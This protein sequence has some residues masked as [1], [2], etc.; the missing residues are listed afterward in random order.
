MRALVLFARQLPHACHRNFEL[1]TFGVGITNIDFIP[2]DP[3]VSILARHF[4]TRRVSLPIDDTNEDS[5]DPQENAIQPPSVMT[6]TQ[7]TTRQQRKNKKTNLVRRNPGNQ[8]NKNRNSMEPVPRNTEENVQPSQPSSS[9]QTQ[10]Q[11]DRTNVS[12]PFLS[13]SIDPSHATLNRTS[14]TTQ[15]LRLDSMEIDPELHDFHDFRLDNRE[16]SAREAK[17]DGEL[18]GPGT[19]ALDDELAGA[20]TAVGDFAQDDIR[21]M[22]IDDIENLDATGVTPVS[23]S[24][25]NPIVYEQTRSST[26]LTVFQ[27]IRDQHHEATP[28]NDSVPVVSATA[29][30]ILDEDGRRTASGQAQVSA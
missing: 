8:Q 14:T 1:E 17:L 21:P 26:F 4:H 2:S 25:D 20:G 18:S 5:I 28:S 29:R 27:R 23:E 16:N 19:A 13:W 10:A 7:E 22:D 3:Q 6:G 12:F 15:P 9:D 30:H 24:K 11:R